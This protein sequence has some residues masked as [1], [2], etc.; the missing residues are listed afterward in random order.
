M[1]DPRILQ[2][3][4]VL[5][6]Y[7]AA[8]Q[9]G[10]RILLEAEPVA[11]PLIRALYKYILEC[12]GH[13][14]LIINLTGQVS[15]SGIDDIFLQNASPDQM[16]YIP[17]FY[18]M[19]YE[20]FESRIRIH[21]MNNTKALSNIDPARIARREKTLQ[22]ILEAQFR[23][24]DCGEFRWVTTQ[25]PTLAYA[26]D[27]EMCLAE[28]EDF[29]YSA[30]HVDDPDLDSFEYWKDVEAKQQ[31]LV[32]AFAGHDEVV[33]RCP[34]CDFR[35]SVK[36]RTFINACGKNNM[37]DGEV[38]T[39]PV[40]NSA[41]G[42]IHFTF[43]AVSRGVEVDGV[44]LRF[45]DGQV[46]EAHADK[47]QDFLQ[48]MLHVDSGASFLGEFAFGLNYGVQKYTKNILFDEKIGG[49]FHIA[50]GAGYP[51]T[52]SKNKSAIHWDMICDLRQES[53]VLLDGKMIFKDGEFQI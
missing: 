29:L 15:Q 42:W 47:N 34:H 41:S 7:S 18:R 43:P 45:E 38:F 1:A 26:Q 37:P 23:R 48:E 2:M 52:G 9:P 51:Q 27:A 5:I 6:N 4:R 8:I 21:S 14:H 35:V 11:E 17:P 53:E 24:G 20:Q 10:D 44:K 22:P 25:F 19:A 16:D 32:E 13:P 46:L 40:E 33:V 36:D 31:R 50:F 49:T 3:A 30:C 28:Y 39:G 12:G